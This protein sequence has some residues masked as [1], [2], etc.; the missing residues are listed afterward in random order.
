MQDPPEPDI[1]AYRFYE[2][3]WESYDELYETFE[4]EVPE[5]FNSAEYLCD[6]WARA[7]EERVV[8]VADG[9]DRDVEKYTFADLRDSANRLANYLADRGVGRGEK[10]L[11][12]GSQR[13]ETLISIVAA[14]KLGAVAVPVSTMLGADGL[15]YRVEDCEAAALVVDERGA[16]AA[17][18]ARDRSENLEAVLVHEGVTPEDDET[19]FWSA[20][21][22]EST[23]FENA[24]TSADDVG[25]IIYTSGT[26]GQPKGVLLPHRVVLGHLTTFAMLVGDLEIRDDDVGWSPTEWTWVATTFVRL[27]SAL[28]Y[29]VTTL[30]YDRGK[31][32]PEEVFEVVEKHGVT[33]LGSAPTALR[34]MSEVDTAPYD[35]SSVRV[36]GGG[37][38]AFGEDLRE[39]AGEAFGDVVGEQGTVDAAGHLGD[40]V[41][42]AGDLLGRTRLAVGGVAYL[43]NAV[44]GQLDVLGDLVERFES[45]LGG[46]GAGLDAGAHLAD[47][48][49][50]VVGR[51]LDV[52]DEPLDLVGGLG[53]LAREALD[54]VGDDGEALA[55]FARPSGLDR[56]VQREH[57]RLLGDVADQGDDLA[58]L[59]HF[60]GEGL[61]LVDGLV[62][63]VLDGVH[64]VDGLAG[65]LAT[66]LADFDRPLGPTGHLRRR[67]GDLLDGARERL[68]LA[69]DLAEA[70]VLLVGVG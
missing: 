11:M 43:L 69:G 22:G 68:H 64:L 48:G 44:V 47:V 35:L 32:D 61:D 23:A 19:E 38:E 55:R 66:V 65:G 26:T 13:P 56:G 1:D 6:R 60:A 42:H 37:G 34:M 50:G 20:L 40:A 16:E 18:A 10:V 62:G 28:Y 5:R 31:F 52:G 39:W 70:L 3:E 21:S 49:D 67:G 45:L 17:R 4:W 9:P 27:F 29:G 15:G 53:G 54:L 46:R 2:E 36:V 30:A 59:V 51:V 12:H 25:T 7:D 57:V 58:D 8:L 33:L 24:A 14:W 41:D 63:A